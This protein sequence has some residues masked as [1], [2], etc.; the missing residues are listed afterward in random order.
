[1]PGPKYVRRGAFERGPLRESQQPLYDELLARYDR[2]EL[3]LLASR[4][5]FDLAAFD[6]LRHEF[7][8]PPSEYGLKRWLVRPALDVRLIAAYAAAAA[9]HAARR[10]LREI[11]ARRREDRARLEQLKDLLLSAQA[12]HATLLHDAL[13]SRPAASGPT[14]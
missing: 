5:P 3:V 7:V 4:L 14:P 8:D 2:D 1:M 6:A 13:R 11:E 10:V 9:P 12:K